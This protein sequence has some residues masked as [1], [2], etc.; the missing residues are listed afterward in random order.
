[1]RVISLIFVLTLSF[2]ASIRGYDMVNLHD[3]HYWKFVN[4]I[5]KYKRDYYSDRELFFEK[6]YEYV[7]N[8]KLIKEHNEAYESNEVSYFLAEGPFTDMNLSEFK[9]TVLSKFIELPKLCGYF[10]SG[11]KSYPVSVDWR[12]RNAVTPVKNQ[13]QCGSCWSFSTTGA[14]E[15]ITAIKSGELVSL[16]EQELVDCSSANSGCNGGLMTFAF[17]YIIK[18]KGLCSENEYQYTAKDG[19]CKTCTTVEGTDIS[20]CKQIKSGDVDNLISALS[21]QP[22]SVAIQADTFAFQHYGGGVFSDPNCYTGDIDHGVLLVAYTNDTL[23]IK[24]S[25][26]ESWGDKGYITFA[27]T[28][29]DVGICGVYTSA[30]FPVK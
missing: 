7:K 2:V 5:N 9:D 6:F 23:T 22:V 15:G 11:D 24:N 25:W 13:G 12:D 14:L 3:E 28:D 8:L 4:F 20:D 17:E 21:N 27:R 1:M 26:G 30:S 18:N 16:S 29:D 10:T 19:T